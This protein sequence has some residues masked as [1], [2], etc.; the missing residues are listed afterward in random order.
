MV[1]LEYSPFT[2][3]WAVTRSGQLEGSMLGLTK[4]LQAAKV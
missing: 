1:S 2:Q 4:Q 3:E